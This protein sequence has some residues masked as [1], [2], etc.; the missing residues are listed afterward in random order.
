M[1]ADSP[2]ALPSDAPSVH[3][4]EL[5]AQVAALPHLPGVYRFFSTDGTLLYVGKARDLRKRVSSY[6]Q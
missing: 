4:P 2:S 3:S 1:T 5:L 6:F